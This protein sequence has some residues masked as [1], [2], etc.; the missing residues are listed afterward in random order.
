[1]VVGFLGA[2]RERRF[3]T[4]ACVRL[5]GIAV[6]AVLGGCGKDGHGI[7]AQ[8]AAPDIAAASA[9]PGQQAAQQSASGDERTGASGKA[10]RRETQGEREWRDVIGTVAVSRLP[11]QAVATLW[12]IEAGGPFPFEKDGVVFGNRE[13]LLPRQP[14]GYYHEYTV[15]TSRTGNR[16]ARRIVCGGP[17][18]QTGDCYYTG[19]HYSSFERIAQ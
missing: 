13:R 9:A 8:S 14:R 2:S 17:P 10:L 12:L 4:R 19:D 11:G 6:C 18:R 1:M 7:G 16:G 3:V 5:C 15:P